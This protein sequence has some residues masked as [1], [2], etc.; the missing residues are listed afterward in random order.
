M[1]GG[2]APGPV[3]PPRLRPGD[4]VRVIAPARSRAFV[5]DDDITRRADERFR[6]MGLR[7]SFGAHVD[8][9]DVFDSSSVGSRITDLHA[10]FADPG[11]A[12]IIAAI[13][14]YNSNELLPHLDWDLIAAHPKVLCGYSDVTALQ[15]AIL[16]R[17]GLVTYSGPHW[18][19]FGMRDHFEPTGAWF[20]RAVFTDDPITVQPASAWSDDRWYQDQDDRTLHPNP[21][22]TVLQHG[23][24]SG[25]VVGGNLCTLN[26][27][28]GTAWMPPL[29]GSVLFLEDDA[30]ST[31]P[32]FAR[33]LTSLLQLP[34]A[35][36]VSGLVLGRFQEA[37]AVSL[38]Q[39][40]AMVARQPSLAGKPVVCG[41]DFGHTAPM[42]TFPI[43]GL[44]V[45]TTDPEPA[46]RITRH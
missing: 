24:A 30:L 40:A 7:L 20:A 17:T 37:S 13:G 27:L 46:L 36:A 14:G 28:Q 8:E 10:A 4:E 33:N 6:E 19:T 32:E 35:D 15:N 39:L 43:G 34:D 1:T 23:S 5:A 21:G 16:V 3:V 42:I 12:G 2:K 29:A 45:L 9:R 41:V 11:V 26:L 22:W 25:P 18:S 44:V 38:E 31:G